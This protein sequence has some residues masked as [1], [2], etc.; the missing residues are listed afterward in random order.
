MYLHV[1]LQPMLGAITENGDLSCLEAVGHGFDRIKFANNTVAIITA[2][3]DTT[4][5]RGGVVAMIGRR[6]KCS[7]RLAFAR[8]GRASAA[9]LI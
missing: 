2:I 9:K 4:F 1:K 3:S 7:K 6:S 5:N 8:G